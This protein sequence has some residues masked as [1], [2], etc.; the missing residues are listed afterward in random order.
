M[1]KIEKK[2]I[3]IRKFCEQNADPRIVKKY[4]RYFK[5]GYDA[6]GL[7]P[8]IFETQRDKW[9]DLWKQELSVNDFILL[10]DRLIATGKYE[11]AGFAIAFIY[12]NTRKLIPEMFEKLGSW[13]ENG[14]ANWAHTDVLSG[15]VLAYFINNNLIGI[16]SL[17][18]WTVSE[19]VWKR[20]AVPVT[21]VEALKTDIPLD[22]I[23]SVIE[24]LM[25][26]NEH[27]VQQGLGWLL[28]EAWKKY[29]GRV[30]EFLLK[31]KDTCGRTII[32][33]ATEKMKKEDRAKFKKARNK[34]LNE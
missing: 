7:T 23:L 19:W 6:Y 34:N 21:L 33:Y 28:R 14:I 4:A 31:W 16:E 2:F 22:K 9:L 1:D 26:D 24:S 25:P 27:K 20:R 3:E 30:E 15:K 5:E 17:E 29:P 8:Q 11:E 12:S 13:L 18:K 10:G 32:Q